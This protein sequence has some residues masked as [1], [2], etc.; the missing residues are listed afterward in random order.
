MNTDNKFTKGKWAVSNHFNTQ[1]A[2]PE[3]SDFEGFA[4][5]DTGDHFAA[6]QIFNEYQSEA[7]ANARLIAA[8]PEMLEALRIAER[9]ILD[10]YEYQEANGLMGDSIEY[11]QLQAKIE[12]AISKATQ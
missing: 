2:K 4:A 1:D 6:V 5:V 10:L 8:A 12:S 7:K 11:D 3:H 9:H